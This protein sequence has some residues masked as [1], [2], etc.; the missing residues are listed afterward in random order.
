MVHFLRAR[1]LRACALPLMSPLLKAIGIG[2]GTFAATMLFMW[3]IA[4]IMNR[5][6]IPQLPRRV[7]PTPTAVVQILQPTSTPP[8][9]TPLGTPLSAP[10][11]TPL[12]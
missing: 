12:P 2:L 6:L 5:P 8:L 10:L 9:S 3:G 11:S 4:R 1:T 7:A